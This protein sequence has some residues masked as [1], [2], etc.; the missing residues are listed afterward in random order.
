[1]T[2]DYRM[3]MANKRGRPVQHEQGGDS[4]WVIVGAFDVLMIGCVHLD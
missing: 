2:S 1:M 4:C 3:D